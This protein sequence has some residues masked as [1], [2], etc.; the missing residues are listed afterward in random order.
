[1][2]LTF[3]RST[4]IGSAFAVFLSALKGRGIKPLLFLIIASLAVYSVTESL[5]IDK[6]KESNR[7][8]DFSAKSDTNAARLRHLQYAK[9]A[10]MDSPIIGQPQKGGAGGPLHSVLLRIVVDYGLMGVLPYLSV[11][12][13]I[14]FVLFKYG[15]SG[16]RQNTLAWAGM[17]AFT[18]ALLDAWT[19]SSGLLVRDV[20]QPVLVGAFIGL[21][22]YQ[23]R[24][25]KAVNEMRR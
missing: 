1:M 7:I 4:I 16:V 14:Y 25:V 12:I 5:N 13:G 9:N 2:A 19:H 21:L 23:D 11:I 17:C 15:R 22:F 24:T 18:V 3:S 8:F 6:A 10:F 20:T